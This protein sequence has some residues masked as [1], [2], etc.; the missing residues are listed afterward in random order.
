MSSPRLHRPLNVLVGIR[1]HWDRADA[2]V[3]TARS[4]VS[5][6]L[7]IDVSIEIAWDL[8]I[9]NLDDGYPDRSI[10]V[11][12]VAKGVQTFLEV[13]REI[14]D[15]EISTEWTDTLLERA[16]GSLRLFIDVSKKKEPVVFWS[17]TRVGLDVNLPKGGMQSPIE[18]QSLFKVRLLD[19]FN[20]PQASLD[21]WANLSIDT[22]GENSAATAP[23]QPFDVLPDIRVLPRPDELLL[24]PPYHL[25]VYGGGN[26]IVE[27]QCSHSPTLQLLAGYLKRWCKVNHQNINHPPA[28]EVNLH[29]SSFGVG[30]TYDRLTLSVEDRNPNF[31]VSPM[32]VL[33]FVEGVL[34]YKSVSVDGTSWIF[35]KDVEFRKG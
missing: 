17:A 4:A 12:S 35:R 24:K 19:C 1:D 11:P 7:G 23:H 5:E 16:G 34:G 6:L 22:I 25:A 31:L 8:L 10:F 30:L 15:S 3:Q 2:P 21:E 26:A 9:L 18:M 13:L 28:V 33:S 32:I 27:V 20:D 29:L 14:L